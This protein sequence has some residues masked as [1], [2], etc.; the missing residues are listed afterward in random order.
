MQVPRDDA[1]SPSYEPSPSEISEAQV[2]RKALA[3]LFRVGDSNRLADPMEKKSLSSFTFGSSEFIPPPQLRSRVLSWLE[4]RTDIAG[5]VRNEQISAR[6]I[7]F[8]LDNTELDVAGFACD[9][10][11]FANNPQPTLQMGELEIKV[12]P[13]RYALWQH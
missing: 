1:G 10:S 11:C 2:A 4:D 9:T 3:K 12:E 13:L 6:S 8:L 7:K 5:L